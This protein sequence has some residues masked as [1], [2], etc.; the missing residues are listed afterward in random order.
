MDSIIYGIKKLMNEIVDLPEGKNF[1]NIK[2]T[3]KHNVDYYCLNCHMRV[4]GD[5][6]TKYP[7]YGKF[8]LNHML[9]HVMVMLD[10]FKVYK[11][12]FL[13]KKIFIDSINDSGLLRERDTFSYWSFEDHRNYETFLIKKIC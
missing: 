10:H 8:C 1:R 7:P 11:Y 4:L 3:T 5:H 6:E 9:I 2:E 13:C 12:N